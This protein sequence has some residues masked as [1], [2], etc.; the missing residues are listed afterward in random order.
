MMAMAESRVMNERN[1]IS[2]HRWAD[3][4]QITKHEL[5]KNIRKA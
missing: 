3:E 1:E 4:K 2:E 5:Q